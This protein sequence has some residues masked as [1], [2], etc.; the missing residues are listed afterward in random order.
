VVGFSVV[1]ATRG[2]CWLRTRPNWLRCPQLEKLAQKA[3]R[4]LETVAGVGDADL[5]ALVRDG[6][7]DEARALADVET[8]GL[9]LHHL[10]ELRNGYLT[11]GGYRA[12]VTGGIDCTEWT[13]PR[14]A[15]HHGQGTDTR[16]QAY[17]RGLR[18]GGHGTEVLWADGESLMIA[19]P[20]G[21]GKTT[22]ELRLLRARLGLGDCTLLG[23]PVAPCDGNILYLAMDRPAQIARA[24]YRMFSED[25][26]E[27]LRQRVKFWKGPPPV[28][29]AKQPGILTAFADEAD[30]CDVY[31]DSIKDAAIGLSDDE[32]GAGYNRARQLLLR[33]GRNLAEL[34]HTVKRGP[35]GKPPT[36]VE[37]IYGSAWITNGTG[38]IILLSGDPGDPI[39]GFRHVRQPADEIGPYRL[40]HDQAAGTL[41]VHHST[42]LVALAAASG[43]NGLSAKDAAA[44]LFST[45]KPTAAQVE[46]AR[47]KLMKLVADGLLQVVE[48]IAAKPGGTPPRAWF[49]S[50]WSAS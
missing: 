33:T 36:A 17:E 35:G 8:V 48:G 34:H 28:D 41:T 26:R 32:V 50:D 30:A 38:S 46:K 42:D 21:L 15:H 16:A 19:G 23:Y 31:L 13:D 9:E 6:R 20:M 25:E 39:V 22:L 18:L 49:P 2:T 7:H 37:D 40:L 44:V 43:I 3:I 24:A 5:A 10:Y 12:M 1:L 45:A 14:K 47:R 29:V 11:H 27:I 4:T